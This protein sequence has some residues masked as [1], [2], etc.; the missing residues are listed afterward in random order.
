MDK[1][2]SAENQNSRTSSNLQ[3]KPGHDRCFVCGADN[4]RGLHMNFS[5]H[6]GVTSGYFTIRSDLESFSGVA[7]GGI[8][9]TL[10]DSAMSRWLYDR[11]IYTFTA[12]IKVRFRRPAAPGEKLFVEAK[13]K[14]QRGR[15]Y[16]MVSRLSDIKGMEVA[17]AEAV[18][19][20]QNSA[21]RQ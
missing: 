7:H 8:L 4:P 12:I 15:R 3:S 10:L 9:T 11:E 21:N 14:F 13:K 1:T 17:S 5:S 18:F 19:V 20:L 2:N 6:D 16:Y